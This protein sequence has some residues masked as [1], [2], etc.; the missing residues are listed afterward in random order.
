[1]FGKF[2]VWFDTYLNIH[3]YLPLQPSHTCDHITLKCS[4]ISTLF[5]E[6][7]STIY[8]LIYFFVLIQL[9]N[10]I[11][12]LHINVGIDMYTTVKLNLHFQILKLK[13]LASSWFGLIHISTYIYTSP[14]S[15]PIYVSTLS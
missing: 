14:Y 13:C 2:L 1:M 8:I 6:Q 4:H 9:W 15:H 7:N 10:G 3:L 12:G 11:N 5:N